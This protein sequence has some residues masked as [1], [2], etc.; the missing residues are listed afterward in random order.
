MQSSKTQPKNPADVIS[1]PNAGTTGEHTDKN[2][3]LGKAHP[4]NQHKFVAELDEDVKELR[5]KQLGSNGY[6]GN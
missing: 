1:T 3:A 4:Q 5:L 6:Q 2:D